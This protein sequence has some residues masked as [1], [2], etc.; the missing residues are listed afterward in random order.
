M[1][2]VARGVSELTL[3]ELRAVALS[4][5]PTAEG[6]RIRVSQEMEVEQV[7]AIIHRGNGRLV[8]VNPVRESLEDLF[9]R[10][11]GESSRA[12]SAVS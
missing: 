4:V 8:S 12:L 3:T 7:L 11:V 10:E 5:I 6:G 9:V 1:E 2:I